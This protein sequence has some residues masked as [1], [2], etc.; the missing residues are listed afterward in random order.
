MHPMRS[1][2]LFLLAILSACG[3]TPTLAEGEGKG[4]LSADREPPA[5]AETA[6]RPT[7]RQGERFIYRRGNAQRFA[8]R[9]VAAGDDGYV[10]EDE[11]SLL[12][13][14]LS[15]DFGEAGQELPEDPESVRVYAPADARYSWPLWVGKR[16]TTQYLFKAPGRPALPFLATYVCDAIEEVKVPAGK[17]RCYRV[18]RRVR[19]AT[20]GSFLERVTLSWYAPEV[21][22]LVKRLDESVLVELDETSR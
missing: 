15:L 2:A 21:G 14:R 1:L 10:L 6:S 8:L 16:W 5:G 11:D 3:G 19:P 18:W 9:V 13:T 7:W 17:F 22:A 20:E 4:L 12:R